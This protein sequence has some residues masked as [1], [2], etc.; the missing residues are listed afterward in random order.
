MNEAATHCELD[1]EF[2]VRQTGQIYTAS[3]FSARNLCS[4]ERHLKNSNLCAGVGIIGPISDLQHTSNKIVD[5]EDEDMGL[6]ED[7]NFEEE[8]YETMTPE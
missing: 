4:E 8:H 3:H 5:R 1:S 2:H 7:E 6:E